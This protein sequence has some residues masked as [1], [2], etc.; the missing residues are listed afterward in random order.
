M[1]QETQWTPFR[2]TSNVF[3]LYKLAQL[4]FIYSRSLLRGVF[5]KILNTKTLGIDPAGTGKG[6]AGSARDLFIE[7]MEQVSA[8]AL[9]SSPPLEKEKLSQLLSLLR[10]QM[11]TRRIGASMDEKEEDS[12]LELFLRSNLRRIGKP[13]PNPA[14]PASTSNPVMPEQKLDRGAVGVDALI[15][16]AAKKFGVSADLVR[17]VV[18]TESAFNPNAV[19][20]KGAMGL[21]QLM[22]ATARDLGVKDP[23][24]PEQN[25][26][27]GTRYLR[28]LLD[29]Y[30]GE[31][32]L[33]LAAYNWGM[34]NLE[35]STGRWP[36]ETLNYVAKIKKMLAKA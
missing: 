4:L 35:R 27:A 12:S 6:R 10:L 31:V 20:S 24:D 30:G 22:P 1:T 26:M 28:G 18:S 3:S 17:A 16:R 5:V 33:A 15:D 13:A 25:V 36:R 23:H 14:P 19:S 9:E 2:Q 29:R 8:G 11:E 34:G 21:M 7:I 32:D